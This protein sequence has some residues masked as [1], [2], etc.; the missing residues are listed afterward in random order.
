[1][2]LCLICGCRFRRAPD[3]VDNARVGEKLAETSDFDVT[4]IDVEHGGFAAEL[5]AAGGRGEEFGSVGEVV[6]EFSDSFFLSEVVE[7][8][9]FRGVAKWGG[10]VEGRGR[11]CGHGRGGGD[12]GRSH[13]GGSGAWESG[14]GGC[15]AGWTGSI[16]MMRESILAIMM[17]VGG[18][19]SGQNLRTKLSRC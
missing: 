8:E 15:K 7:G 19:N 17:G 11:W 18:I 6:T 9:G 13:W 16:R 4:M 5:E 1:M 10:R 14:A 2:F 12:V 3:R